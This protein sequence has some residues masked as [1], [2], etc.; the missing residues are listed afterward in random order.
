MIDVLRDGIERVPLRLAAVAGPAPEQIH[1]LSARL[2]GAWGFLALSD[3]AARARPRPVLVVWP[4]TAT[5]SYLKK[6]VDQQ[7]AVRRFV[8]RDSVP[9]SEVAEKIGRTERAVCLKRCKLGI[10]T[11]CDGRKQEE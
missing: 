5:G 2:F 8:R 10:P 1:D 4:E 3:R 11:A 9:L 7:I 6:Q